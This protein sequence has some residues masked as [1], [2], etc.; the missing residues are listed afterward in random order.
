MAGPRPTVDAKPMADGGE[1]G[2]PCLSNADLIWQNYME[3][4]LINLHWLAEKSSGFYGS[5]IFEASSLII[6]QADTNLKIPSGDHR[7]ISFF[8]GIFS[9]KAPTTTRILPL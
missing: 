3:A 5:S 1:D 7:V 6:N 8:W 2:S 4:T 9:L